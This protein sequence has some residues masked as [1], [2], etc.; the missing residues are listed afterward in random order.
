MVGSPWDGGFIGGPEVASDTFDPVEA[1][2]GEEALAA[3]RENSFDCV[4]LDLRLPDMTGFELLEGMHSDAELAAIPV[5][6]FT[7]KELTS[8]EQNQ[9]KRFAK[10]G[11]SASVIGAANFVDLQPICLRQFGTLRDR[12]RIIF[13]THC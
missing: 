11:T 12:N 10:S 4:V 6:V 5:V 9:L 7:G 1:G 2:T 8:D 3:M 13:G